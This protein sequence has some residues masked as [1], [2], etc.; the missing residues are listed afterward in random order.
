MTPWARVVAIHEELQETNRL[1]RTLLASQGVKVP[2]KA[3]GHLEPKTAADVF[4][5][6]RESLAVQQ[7]AERE[8]AVRALYGPPHATPPPENS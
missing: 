2:P 4:V 6:T 3:R 5:Q 8:R 1:L 7:A